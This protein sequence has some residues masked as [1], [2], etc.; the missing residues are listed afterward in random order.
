MG[1][2]LTGGLPCAKNETMGFM[3]WFK[4]QDRQ[5]EAQHCGV[6]QNPS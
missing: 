4:V 2:D 5:Y 3:R 6:H 1:S